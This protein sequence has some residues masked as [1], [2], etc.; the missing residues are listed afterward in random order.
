M[1]DIEVLLP[2]MGESVAEATII[3][4]LK[5]EGDTIEADE[6]IIEIATDKVDSEVPAPADGILIKRLFNEGDVVNVGEVI[7]IIGTEASAGSST[8]QPVAEA[9][10]ATNGVSAQVEETLM[11]PVGSNGNGVLLEK[12]GPSG[13][14][15]SPLVRSIAQ[16][17]GIAIDELEQ[18]SGSGQNGRVT[19]K[20]I[21][22]YIPN[23]GTVAT[24]VAAVAQPAVKAV[25]AAVKAPV[26]KPAVHKPSVP[27]GPND[28]VI[29]MDRMRKLIADHMVKSVQTAPHVTSFVEADVTNLVLWRNKIKNDFLAREGEKLTFTPIFI[30][31]IAK[32]LKDFPMVNSSIDGNNIIVKKDINI[33]M[34]AA[35]PSLCPQVAS[36]VLVFTIIL[37]GCVTGTAPTT[38]QPLASISAAG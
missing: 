16:A 14:F 7:A 10:T 28:E 38:T 13:K 1:A 24:P 15:Y 19:K 34:A 25:P 31:A 17:E 20:D 9:A 29:E 30:E 27:I 26:A 23:K 37:D 2:K 18:I 21:L 36:E 22:A 11:A 32:A 8:A 12:T 3:K 35:L 33:G 5:E 4:W 6:S